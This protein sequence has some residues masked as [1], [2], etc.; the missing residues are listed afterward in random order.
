VLYILIFSILEL[1]CH[2][3]LYHI[4]NSVAAA[5]ADADDDDELTASH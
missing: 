3:V 4:V 1:L 2:T 5:A